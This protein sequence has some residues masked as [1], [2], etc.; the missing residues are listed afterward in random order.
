MTD[1]E[2]EA[3]IRERAEAARNGPWTWIKSDDSPAPGYRFG[4]QHAMNESGFAYTPTDA[5][6]IAH[7]REDVPFL[8]DAL[9]AAR[10][11][12]DA[13][14]EAFGDLVAFLSKESPGKMLPDFGLLMS[15]ARRELGAAKA[16]PPQEFTSQRRQARLVDTALRRERDNLF[17]AMNALDMAREIAVE[18]HATAR[19]E[20]DAITETLKE[21]V[22]TL[23]RGS[24]GWIADTPAGRAAL[25]ALVALTPEEP[26][27]PTP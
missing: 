4:G 3:E 13:L 20:R 17:R 23:L 2:R 22:D 1:T 6:F 27:E 16:W 5:E 12:R 9:S 8:L 25:T 21:L 7:A 14:T 19:R 11:E 24:P 10:R 18:A 26:E 15:R